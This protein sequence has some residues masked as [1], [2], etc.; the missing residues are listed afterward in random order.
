MQCV[1]NAKSM[2]GCAANQ[3]HNRLSC[4]GKVVVKIRDGHFG[5]SIAEV[6]HRSREFPSDTMAGLTCNLQAAHRT[7]ASG[8]RRE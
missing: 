5:R 2:P 8:S 7:A 1:V 6:D 4:Q 3:R